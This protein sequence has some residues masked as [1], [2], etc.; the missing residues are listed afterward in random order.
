MTTLLTSKPLK[1]LDY[2]HIQIYNCS[3]CL[4][5]CLLL[6]GNLEKVPKRQ[7][8]QS[9]I[10]PRSSLSFN[11]LAKESSRP[12]VFSHAKGYEYRSF[13]TCPHCTVTIGYTSKD[14]QYVYILRDAL[15]PS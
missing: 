4:E 1:E 14:P 6:Y 10:L 12:I 3:C 2:Q 8:D 7:T 11:L 13:L 9:F 15:L 5:L